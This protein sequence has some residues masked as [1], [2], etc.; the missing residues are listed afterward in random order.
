MDLK[1]HLVQHYLP[2]ARHGMTVA[3]PLWDA[4]HH[5]RGSHVVETQGVSHHQ[6]TV[7]VARHGPGIHRAP[8]SHAVET[9]GVSHH[10]DAVKV[11]H[12]GPDIHH[13]PGSQAVDDTQVGHHL[14]AVKAALQGPDIHHGPGVALHHG[15][16]VVLPEDAVRSHD[17]ALQKTPQ[18]SLQG[19]FFSSSPWRTDAGEGKGGAGGE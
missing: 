13:V 2:H 11:V 9:Q 3:F 7:K 17:Q 18:N 19:Q 12:H 10:Q 8:G 15:Y 4:D 5:V 14:G 16:P 1:E 6:D